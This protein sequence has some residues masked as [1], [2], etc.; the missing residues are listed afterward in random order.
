MIETL[1]F[2]GLNHY[3]HGG[4]DDLYSFGGTLEQSKAFMEGVIYLQ[5][6]HIVDYKTMKII[7]HGIYTP[8]DGWV[9]KDIDS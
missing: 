1:L 9:W 8:I 5:W 7:S 6:A 4:M 2:A 3:P